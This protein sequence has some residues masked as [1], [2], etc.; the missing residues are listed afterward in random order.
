MKTEFGYILEPKMVSDDVLI[1]IISQKFPNELTYTTWMKSFREEESV[2]M[3]VGNEG[4][5][6]WDI[7]GAVKNDTELE[8]IDMRGFHFEP[9]MMFMDYIREYH[10]EVFV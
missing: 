8:L 5:A 2:V 1:G 9:K 10:P 3:Y 6:G 4:F 7:F